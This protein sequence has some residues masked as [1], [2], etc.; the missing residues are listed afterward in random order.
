MTDL[1]KT[2][3]ELNDEEELELLDGAS[4]EEEL[5][6]LDDEL[7]PECEEDADDESIRLAR[8]QKMIRR[9]AIIAGVGIG[10]AIVAAVLAILL[11]R[12]KED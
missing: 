3:E 2:T 11:G 10:V 1:E 4:E 7:L 8:K 5:T 9:V 12:S 6:E